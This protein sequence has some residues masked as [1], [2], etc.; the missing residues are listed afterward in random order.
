MKLVIGN[1]NYSSWSLRPWLVLKQLDIAF[2]EIRIPFE[3]YDSLRARILP[4]SPNAKVPALIDGDLVVWESLAICE[5]LNDKFPA[6]KLWPEDITARA[7]AR[8]A[9]CEMHAAFAKLREHMTLNCRQRFPGKGRA[10]GVAEDIARVQQLWQDCRARFGAGGEF[11]F[12]R[13]SIADA[14]FAPVVFRFV[15]YAVALDSSAQRYVDHMMQL[16]SMQAWLALARAEPEV[17]SRY[18]Y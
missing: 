11:L 1:P 15:T 6:A 12:G 17:V 3:P 4:Y 5:Y 7:V 13:F 14:M 2:E 16:P 9:S 18:E 10:P 8:A